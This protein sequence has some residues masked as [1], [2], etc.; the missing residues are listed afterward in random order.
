LSERSLDRPTMAGPHG[1]GESEVN[2]TSRRQVWQDAH[3]DETTRSLLAEDARYFLRQ[4]V[5]TPCLSAIRRAEGI[6]I[7]DAT[8]RRYI[9]AVVNSPSSVWLAGFVTKQ[10]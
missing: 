3:L 2:F 8:G 7:E 10:Q 6:W 5:S 9:S 4:S 1:R